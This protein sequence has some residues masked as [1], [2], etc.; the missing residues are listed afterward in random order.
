MEY[1]EGGELLSLLQRKGKLL[2][3]EAKLFVRQ[4]VEAINY[5]H[6]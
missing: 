2:E 4:I 6:N 3:D 5:C 1:L